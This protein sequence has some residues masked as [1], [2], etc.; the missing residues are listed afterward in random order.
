MNAQKKIACIYFTHYFFRG[1]CWAEKLPWNVSSGVTTYIFN[2]NLY[3]WCSIT[4]RWIDLWIGIFLIY[5]FYALKPS[6]GK[7]NFQ[8]NNMHCEIKI[9]ISKL[10]GNQKNS[11]HQ[12]PPLRVSSLVGRT[13]IVA[14]N[15]LVKN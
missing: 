1:L 3:F 13:D 10:S 8:T 9:E 6:T 14:L 5:L 7:A 12:M 4:A 11:K 15:F 2:V